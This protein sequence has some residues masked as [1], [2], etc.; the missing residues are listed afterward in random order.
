MK[1]IHI[2]SLL[3]SLS[4]SKDIQTRIPQTCRTT[5]GDACIFPFTFKGQTFTKC[6]Y[7]NS[8][9]PWCATMVDQSGDV[10]TNRFVIN[11][12]RLLLISLCTGGAI[13]T[14]LGDFRHVKLTL[15]AH[16]IHLASQLQVQ[17]KTDLAFSPL[18][19]M[20]VHTLLALM[21]LSA[22]FG[23]RLLQ[24]LMV[25]T[26]L[27]SMVFAHQHAHQLQ[28][29]NWP[30]P[31]AHL[32][33]HGRK[34]ATHVSVLQLVSQAVQRRFAQTM[35]A[36]L[37]QARHREELALSHLVLVENLMTVVHSGTLEVWTKEKCGVQPGN[38]KG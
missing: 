2:C 6:T 30:L 14:L 15:T 35:I 28:V 24:N 12:I 9:T 22:N 23:V 10:V 20:D 7:A 33:Q 17:W 32:D 13:V 29:E 21:L 26:Y 8:P 36:E 34:T 4:L 16:Q 19:T 11:L 25:L 1:L 38:I 27:T 18:N 5:S 3:P 31:A 37:L